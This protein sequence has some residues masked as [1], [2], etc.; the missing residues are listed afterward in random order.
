V[1]GMT[2]ESDRRSLYSPPSISSVVTRSQSEGTKLLGRKRE[3]NTETLHHMEKSEKPK[4][5]FVWGT[6]SIL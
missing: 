5:A 1:I 6:A 3:I 4:S 2:N